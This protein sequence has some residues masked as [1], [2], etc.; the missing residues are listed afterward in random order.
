MQRAPLSVG[1]VQL[2]ACVLRA[3]GGSFGVCI[4]RL[5]KVGYFPYKRRPT[6]R[7][8]SVIFLKP[9]PRLT[10]DITAVRNTGLF[11]WVSPGLTLWIKA[12]FVQD[13]ARSSKTRET[14][15]RL[16]KMIQHRDQLYPLCNGRLH[17]PLESMADSIHLIRTS[18]KQGC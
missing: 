9:L 6:E 18:P 11:D 5:Y 10:H 14:A 13:A 8:K 4:S 17:S 16:A 12:V 2:Q 15:V 7:A 3:R 1:H